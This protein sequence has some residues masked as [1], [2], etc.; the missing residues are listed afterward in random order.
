MRSASAGGRCWW[1]IWTSNRNSPIAPTGASTPNWKRISNRRSQTNN[2]TGREI[3]GADCKFRRTLYASQTISSVTREHATR[4][5]R[6]RTG[7]R[8]SVSFGNGDGGEH[9][10]GDERG[11][12]ATSGDAKFRWS[13][14]SEGSVSRPQPVSPVRRTVA[15]RPLQRAIVAEAARF[16]GRGCADAGARYRREHRDL[17]GRQWRVNPFASLSR[18]LATGLDRWAMD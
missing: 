11:R 6:T 3:A 17:Y 2:P 8:T 12:G 14:A 9:A 16:S 1:Q 7:T 10:A 5:D 13:R 18:S 4:E 15:G